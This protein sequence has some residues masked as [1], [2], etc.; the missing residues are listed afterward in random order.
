MQR[1]DLQF[2]AFFM[3]TLSGMVFGVLFDVLRVLRGY[4]RPGR[5]LAALADLLFWGAAALALGVGLFMGNWGEFRF[6]VLIALL[7]GLGLYYWLGSP[8]MLALLYSLLRFLTW[9]LELLWAP[10][11]ALATL[12]VA[13]G[14]LLWQWALTLLGAAGRL[15]AWLGRWLSRP[16]IRPYRCAKLHYLLTKRRVK[17]T[18]RRWLLGPRR[19]PR[20]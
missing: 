1:V 12:L 18:L 10:V 13:T 2:Y 19:P 8:T 15:L 11:V 9:L 16:L 4:Y 20:E 3:T 7:L 5:W 6:Y 14:R 17:R